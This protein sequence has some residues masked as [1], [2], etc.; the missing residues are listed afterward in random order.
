MHR[1]ASNLARCAA[2]ATLALGGLAFALPANA[3]IPGA[4][5]AYLAGLDDLRAAYVALHHEGAENVER[6]QS[7]ALRD[8]RAAYGD[9]R[10]AAAYDGKD[11]GDH[12]P[13]DVDGRGRLER[14][15]NALRQAHADFTRYESNGSDRGWQHATVVRVDAAIAHVRRAMADGRWDRNHGY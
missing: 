5:P 3:D 1:F 13:V 4:H 11:L 12:P 2:A 15:L 6:E 8:I 14:A 9:A 10:R 7:A